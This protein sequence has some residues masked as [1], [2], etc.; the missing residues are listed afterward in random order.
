MVALDFLSRPLRP[1]VL[2]FRLAHVPTV[3]Y[4]PLS[5]AS[6]PGLYA[7]LHGGNADSDRRR[8]SPVSRRGGVWDQRAQRKRRTPERRGEAV[9]RWRCA[10]GIPGRQYHGRTRLAGA[11]AEVAAGEISSGE[12]L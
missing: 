8:S 4:L 1:S 7:L 6:L 3:A 9:E 10:S 2:S 11:L 12:A 5:T